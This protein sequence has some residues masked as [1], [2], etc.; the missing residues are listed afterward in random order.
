MKLTCDYVLFTCIIIMLYV[1]N[2]YQ[3]VAQRN[4]IYIIPNAL[5]LEYFNR[6][7]AHLSACGARNT[8]E[9][10]RMNH[11]RRRLALCPVKHKNVYAILGSLLNGYVLNMFIDYRQYPA[12]SPGMAW[13]RDVRVM[14]NPDYYEAVLTLWND[15]DSTFDYVDPTTNQVTSVRTEPNT[16]VLV[17]PEGVMHRVSPS[18]TGTREIVKCVFTKS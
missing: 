13:H 14:S 2:H 1:Y 10:T 16:L 17:R 9:P 4:E 7:R 18:R 12:G 5:P 3:T 15:S 8:Q 6:L 11:G